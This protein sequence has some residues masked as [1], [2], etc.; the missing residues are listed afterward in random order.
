MIDLFSKFDGIIAE[1]EALAAT[2]VRDPFGIVMDELKS[3]TVAMIKGKETILVGTYN[4][5]G[6]TFD[7]DVIQAGKDA[8][9]EFGSG[10]NGSRV[11]KD[12]K[13]TRLNSSHRNTSRM[14]SSA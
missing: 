14:P 3:P 12:R 9:D 4:Y 2:G 8:L 1:R 6:M 5:M 13:S 11:L 7:P 10:T